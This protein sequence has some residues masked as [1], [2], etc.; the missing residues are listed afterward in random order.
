MAEVGNGDEGGEGEDDGED[1]EEDVEE[2]DDVRGAPLATTALS[3]LIIN[4]MG[5][6]RILRSSWN[7]EPIRST[8]GET[9]DACEA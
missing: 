4:A 7:R 3:L 1:E 5:R 2:S 8:S 9:H 6:R